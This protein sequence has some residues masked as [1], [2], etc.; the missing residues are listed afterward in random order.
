MKVTIERLGHLGDGIA[1]GPI[2]VPLTLPG[3]EVEGEVV[4]GKMSAPRIL[5]PSVERVKPICSHYKACGG[6]SLM[7]ASDEFVAEWK[8]GVVKTAL[9][10][11]GLNA[12]FRPIHTSPAG[13]RRRAGLAGKRTKNGAMIGFHTRGTGTLIEVPNC[14]LLDPALKEIV[15]ALIELTIAGASRKAELS[16]LVTQSLGGVDVL[17]KG[18]KPLDEPARVELAQIANKHELARLTWEDSVVCEISAPVQVFGSARVNPPGGTFLQAT[19][20][21]EKALVSAVLDAVS[22][23][24]KVVDL[25][26]GCGTFSL[27]VAEHAEVHAVEGEKEMLKAL[28][29]GWRFSTGLKHVS[30]EARD[31]FRRPL[32]PDEFKGFD[33]IVIDP[34]RAGAEAQIAEIAKCGVKRIAMVSCNP[35][36]FAR[37][38]RVLVDAGYVIDWVQV[39]DQFRWS[40]HVEVAAKFTMP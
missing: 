35:V 12:E 31:L 1:E 16:F 14:Q 24:K 9:D 2:F 6:C 19:P 15:P 22:G 10:G 33:A 20:Q 3:E 36:T 21:G 11:Q 17:V 27:P 28:D 40:P 34:P 37:D 5:I 39:V 4:D 29:H 30:T 26:A 38:A 25:F 8:Q 32:L 23:A 7:H 13:S 18:G